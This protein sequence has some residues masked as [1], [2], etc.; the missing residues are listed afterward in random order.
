MNA[1]LLSFALCA[2]TR[3]GPVEM[4]LEECV[5]KVLADNVGL[6][7]SALGNASRAAAVEEALGSF[8]PELYASVTGADREEPTA[9]SFTAPRN[10]SLNGGLGLRGLF[11]SGMTYDLGYQLSY[12]RQSPTNPFFGFNP[13]LA[14]DLALNVTQPLLRG[15]GPT[16]TEAPVEQARLLLV[17]GDLELD[18]LLQETAFRAVE[19]Y[20][21]L[22]RSRKERDTARNALEVAEELVRNNQRR[23]AAG[24]MTRLDV[25]TAQA[26]AARRKET[27]IRAQ[28]A[29]G[30][31]EDALKLLLS[32]GANPADWK[33]E[34]VPTS[35]AGVREETL[36]DEEAVIL[37]AFASRSDLRALEVDLRAADLALAVAEN[38]SRSQL[39][40]RGSYGFAGLAGKQAGGASKNNVDL[41]GE[42]LGQIR[43]REFDQW[44]L[45][46]DFAHP[47]GN[48]AGEA[49]ERRAQ[50]EK[51][52]SLMA[53]LERRMAI[54]Q[55]LRGAVRDVNDAEAAY[56]AARQ[57]RLLAE[58][59]YQAELTRLENEHSTTF[60]V[61]EA[62]RDLF[63]ARD[64]ETAAITQYEV[65]RAGLSRAKGDLARQYGVSVEI[66]AVE[67][68]ALR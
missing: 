22:V 49:G 50:I 64:R 55:E 10:Q 6:H 65:L 53:L 45:G 48:R 2:A 63:E 40:L 9:S 44:S 38:S 47:I 34:I 51:E 67:A 18:Q 8:D 46:V 59:Q 17:R 7:L 35:E 25:L 31:S 37:A 23:L 3:D 56:A 43:D 41:W 66:E 19:A 13:T 42:S 20:W 60:Q 32:P 12:N 1:I 62:Q 54:V 39:D 27:L 30:R 58:E 26:E 11:R 14:S 29:V 5:R 33:G 24:V 57:A 15:F 28:N 68:G 16:V 21:T 52:R 4:S 36:P 61:R